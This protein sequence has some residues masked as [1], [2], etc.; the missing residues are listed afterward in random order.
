MRAR[1][2]W[3]TGSKVEFEGTSAEVQKAV[4]EHAE[5]AH[6]NPNVKARDFG[7]LRDASDPEG[8]R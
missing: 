2:V 4:F 7:H 1:C 6:E 3:C 5:A 8:D